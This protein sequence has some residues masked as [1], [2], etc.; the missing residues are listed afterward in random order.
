M[1]ERIDTSSVL[2]RSANPSSR[3]RR[4]CAYEPQ[5]HERLLREAKHRGGRPICK[6]STGPALGSMRLPRGV[7]LEMHFLPL[8]QTGPTQSGAPRAMHRRFGQTPPALVAHRSFSTGVLECPTTI[9]RKPLKP[10]RI[11][12]KTRFARPLITSGLRPAGPT[13][14]I[15]TFGARP[16]R[17]LQE[18]GKK[19]PPAR[20]TIASSRNA[21]SP[22]AQKPC[23][24]PK[25]ARLPGAKRLRSGGR[26]DERM[27]TMDR[28]R[29]AR[30]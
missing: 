28:G 14:G 6:Q 7:A 18:R 3:S 10:K 1:S 16:S 22:S 26:R 13:A 11:L 20:R 17:N 8:C 12:S 5:S 9:N 23:R 19:R 15:S 2:R 4:R 24:R 30:Q 29:H 21:K 25:N 27:R